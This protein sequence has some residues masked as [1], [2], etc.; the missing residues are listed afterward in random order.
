MTKGFSLL[1]MLMVVF[2]IGLA[3]AL[4]TPNLPLVFDRLAFANQRDSFYRDINTLPY[5]AFEANQDLFLAQDIQSARKDNTDGI[6][7]H[8]FIDTNTL[9]TSGPYLSSNLRAVTLKV[10]EKWVLQI[11]EPIFYRASGFCSGG[12]I[13]ISAGLLTNELI[14]SPPYCQ[15]DAVDQ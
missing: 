4:V 9:N 8:Q 11:P 2:I 1:E 13:I 6:S 14:L 10:P 7:D 15:I 3:A 12:R 5:A